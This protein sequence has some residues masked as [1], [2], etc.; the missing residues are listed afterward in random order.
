MRTRI[1]IAAL[2]LASVLAPAAAFAQQGTLQI[3]VDQAPVGLDPDIVT[4]FSS[5]AV[6]DQIYEGLLEVNGKLQLEP[7]LATDWT[8]S[9][10]GLSYVFN[11]RHGVKFHNGRE[12]TSADVV[13]SFNRI[14][15]PKTGSPQASR[16]SQVASIDATG[17]YQVTFKL[18][19]PFAPFLSN[20]TNLYVVPKEVVEAN[21]DLQKVAV[22]TGPYEL[23]K[24]V[25]DTYVLLKANPDYYRPGEPKLAELKFNVVPEAST[26]AAG[27]RTGTYQLLPTVDPVT[28]QT[29]KNASGVRVVGTQDL[30]YSLLGLNVSR[31]PFNDPKVREAINYA[32]NRPD[33]VQAVYLGNAVPGGPLSPALK[34]WAVPT[35][36]YPCYAPS[37]DKAKQL[38][39]EAGYPNGFSTTI[40]TFGTIKEVADTAQVLQAQLAKVGID[41]KVDVEEFGKFVQDWKNSNFD[42]FVSLNGG[43]TDP[44]G[45]LYRTF[46]TGGSTNVF[47]FSDPSVDQLL[48]QGRTTT[49]MGKR[50]AIYD[51]LQKQLACT[52]PIVHIAYGT[53]FTGLRDNVQGF[54][55]LPTRSLRPLRATSLK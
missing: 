40:V 7:A 24:V 35:S 11:L 3:A 34:D 28:A 4:A 13:Y 25:P 21:G 36:Q 2:A 54:V 33:I 20:L 15:D 18:K 16:F 51:D 48:E 39:A 44:D 41:A 14:M 26:R 43:S 6:V 37:V 5:F 17:P 47:K 19:E 12:M 8:V 23:E 50:Q 31:K 32:V 52:G 53:L 38:L 27:L 45:Y 10:D 42:M 22:G 9:S 46:H 49:D 55:Q 1:V 30:A 29:L